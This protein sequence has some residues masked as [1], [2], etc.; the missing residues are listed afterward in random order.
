MVCYDGCSGQFN[1]ER[2]YKT[3]EFDIGYLD[4]DNTWTLAGSNGIFAIYLDGRHVQTVRIGQEEAVKHVTV[5]LN[6][7][8]LLKIQGANGS[9]A[10]IYNGTFGFAN[11]LL[12]S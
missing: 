2:K 1:L 8:G 11:A 9:S 4:T 3:L 6:N 10:A 12:K 7:A 5:N